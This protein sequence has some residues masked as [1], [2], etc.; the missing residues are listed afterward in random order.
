M[1]PTILLQLYREDR[2]LQLCL[3]EGKILNSNKLYYLKLTFCYILLMVKGFGKH[4]HRK[5]KFHKGKPKIL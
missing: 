1:N 3:G 2:D 4:K 5:Q